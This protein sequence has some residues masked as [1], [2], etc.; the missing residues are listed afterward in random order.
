MARWPSGPNRVTAPSNR[1]VAASTTANGVPGGLAPH[2]H[3]VVDEGL[4]I[5][6][7]ERHREGDPTGDLRILAGGKDGG[8]IGAPPRPEQQLVHGQRRARLVR[9]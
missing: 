1:S 2:G 8:Y 6:R 7:A 4:G 5:R 3:R 9:P